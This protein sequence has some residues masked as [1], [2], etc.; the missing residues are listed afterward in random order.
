MISTQ[1]AKQPQSGVP[2]VNATPALPGNGVLHELNAEVRAVVSDGLPAIDKDVFATCWQRMGAFRDL[3]LIAMAQEVRHQ[4]RTGLDQAELEGR[5]TAATQ[6]EVLARLLENA[7]DFAFALLSDRQ[8]VVL[9][10]ALLLAFEAD[11]DAQEVIDAMSE[12]ANKS[13]H[14]SKGRVSAMSSGLAGKLDALVFSDQGVKS[15]A[16]ATLGGELAL[17]VAGG[18]GALDK[19]SF[20]TTWQRAGTMRDLMLVALAHEARRQYRD[21]IIKAGLAEEQN[22]AI[23]SRVLEPLMQNV[24]DFAFEILSKRQIVVLSSALALAFEAD[25]E[26]QDLAW[27]LGNTAVASEFT[28][29]GRVEAMVIGVAGQYKFD[30]EPIHTLGKLDS[31]FDAANA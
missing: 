5:F 18:P 24:T 3:M 28:S 11:M 17:I 20:G 15:G 27:V 25:M 22:M 2:Q 16:P 31:A 21:A 26:P 14:K 23:R 1:A 29:G 30:I 19:Q 6:S 12:A 4:F 9:S 7:V 10:S 8:I 13:E